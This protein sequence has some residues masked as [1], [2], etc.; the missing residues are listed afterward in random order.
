LLFSTLTES[1]TIGISE[2]VTTEQTWTANSPV[3]EIGNLAYGF[4]KPSVTGGSGN[5]LTFKL[6]PVAVRSQL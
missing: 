3:I 2:D 4:A 1:P 6:T 5:S